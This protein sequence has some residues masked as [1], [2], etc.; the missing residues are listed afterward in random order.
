MATAPLAPEVV[1]CTAIIGDAGSMLAQACAETL[2][3]VAA[4]AVVTEA[5]PRYRELV[6]RTL[7]LLDEI[8]YLKSQGAL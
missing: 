2:R 8:R 3:S 1:D 5:G 6:Q 4:A 7:F